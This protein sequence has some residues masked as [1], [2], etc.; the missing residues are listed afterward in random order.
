MRHQSTLSTREESL[1]PV[2][3]LVDTFGKANGLSRRDMA[4]NIFDPYDV[5]GLHL[6]LG[7]RI[8]NGHEG[9]A[10]RR[11][12]KPIVRL[13]MDS[14]HTPMM[15]LTVRQAGCRGASL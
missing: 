1:E 13:D 12:E 3:L 4:M 6:N 8:A 11:P 10:S 14:R 2:A 5:R 15:S 7:H 9:C